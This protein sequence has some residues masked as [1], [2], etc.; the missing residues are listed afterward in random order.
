MGEQLDLEYVR[1]QFPALAGEW[2]FFD[3]AGGSQALA[4]VVERVSDFLLT[5]NVQVGA[6]YAVSRLATERVDEARRRLALYLNATD[7]DE[8]VFGGATTQLFAN[9]A[10][11]MAAQFRPGDEVIVTNLDHEANVGP[12]VRL[13][14]E[15]G[16]TVRV[17]KVNPETCALDL[18]DLDVLLTERTRL[19]CLTWASNVVGTINDIAEVSRRAHRA[20]ARV[21]VDAVAY[22]PHRALDVRASGAD[23]VCFS[24]Y[25][26]YGP[27]Q[28]VLWGRKAELLALAGINHDFI[29]PE[30]IPYKLQ[31]GNANFELSWGCTGIVDYFV[32]LGGLLGAAGNER[33]RIETAFRAVAAHEEVL[34]E[35]L[36][37]FLRG[38]SDVRI[39]GEAHP[40]RA[41]RMPTVSFTV[42][43]RHASEIP[44]HVDRCKIGIRWGDF[45][46]RRLIADLGLAPMGG[47]VRVSMVHYNTLEEVD[48]LIGVLEEAL[49]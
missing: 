3:N 32:E 19:V 21:V 12:W 48:R 40:A 28:A 26:T 9:L 22:A 46:A 16:L 44:A 35:R 11:A 4:R 38:R 42:A 13:A 17:W 41:R 39:L 5:S 20:G 1:R 8:V 33:E 7:P 15:R 25:K 31:P 29:G 49:G 45:Y 24:T 27:H 2:T 10:L 30:Q 36:L 34:A 43:G 47:V 18:D 14:A 23:F 37:A 6:S